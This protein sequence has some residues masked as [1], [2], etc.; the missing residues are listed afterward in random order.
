MMFINN[1]VTYLKKF[2]NIL[3]KEEKE[4]FNKLKDVGFGTII[5]ANRIQDGEEIP[6]GH[7]VGPFIVLENN[8]NKLICSYGTS[9]VLTSTDHYRYMVFNENDYTLK[10]HTY[11]D[12]SKIC[13]LD[14]SGVIN[15]IREF[16]DK[17][18]EILNKKLNILTNRKILKDYI[19]KTTKPKLDTGDIIRIS[20]DHYLVIGREN[21]DYVCL[22]LSISKNVD[23]AKNIYTNKRYYNVNYNAVKI[24][25]DTDMLLYNTLGSNKL[26]A[27]LKHYKEYTDNKEKR[28]I[29]QRGSIVKYENDYYYVYGENGNKW[30]VFSVSKSPVDLFYKIIVN[31]KNYF[32]DFN[33]LSEINKNDI[34]LVGF[35]LAFVDEMERISSIRKSAKFDKKQE[36]KSLLKSKVHKDFIPGDIIQTKTLSDDEYV[37]IKRNDE[38][39]YC[40][41]INEWNLERPRLYTFKVDFIKK[42]SS[43]LNDSKQKVNEKI[44]KLTQAK[45]T[46]II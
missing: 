25:K 26:L 42:S 31:N 33:N 7:K 43:K 32:T 14:Y 37:I 20:Y 39:V 8:G 12:L 45:K 46:R 17:D 10:K 4:L 30:L 44:L 9:K 19:P 18:K 40:I 21:D 35:D 28:K 23:K 36:E 6:E 5:L 29:V 1:I 2:F 24:D 34:A 38:I 15:I 16:E 13:E 11:F 27:V 3:S 22:P 41:D